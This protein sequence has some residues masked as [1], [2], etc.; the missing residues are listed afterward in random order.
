M[1]SGFLLFIFLT[2]NLFQLCIC[3]GNEKCYEIHSVTQSELESMPRNTIL[4]SLPLK[5]KCFLK[6]LMDDILGVDGRIDLS[7]IDGNEELEPRRN[8]LE[9]C[10]ERYDSYIINNADEACDYAVKVLQCLRV[11]KN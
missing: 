3:H 5:I 6:C 9:K 10:K 4:D 7:R 1:Q 11:T 8:K 2:L